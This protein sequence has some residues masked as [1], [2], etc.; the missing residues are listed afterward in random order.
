[1]SAAAKF[2][3]NEELRLPQIATWWCGQKRERDYVLE[4]LPNLIIKSID[5]SDKRHTY[6]AD[7]LTKAELDTL[8]KKILERPYR[9]T[10]QERVEFSTTPSLV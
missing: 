10:G 8:R 9:F 7:T 4:N 6:I 5:R 2:F 3:L 1:M